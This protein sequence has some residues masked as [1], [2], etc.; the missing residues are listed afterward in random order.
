MVFLMLVYCL[1]K[2]DADAID[3]ITF[4]LPIMKE[5]GDQVHIKTKAVTAFINC[6]ARKILLSD[7]TV[8]R[9]CYNLLQKIL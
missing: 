3:G 2:G 4:T 6:T 5:N 1:V 9:P 8:N 7:V